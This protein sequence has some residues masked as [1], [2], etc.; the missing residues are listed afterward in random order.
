MVGGNYKGFVEYS[1]YAFNLDYFLP[2]HACEDIA[3]P[4]AGEKIDVTGESCNTGAND[5]NDLNEHAPG[6]KPCVNV[7][8]SAG[9]EQESA[10][11]TT[12]QAIENLLSPDV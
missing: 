5:S 10:E 12:I 3:N 6:N 9:N 2:G 7:C 1:S 11:Q 8:T 4:I